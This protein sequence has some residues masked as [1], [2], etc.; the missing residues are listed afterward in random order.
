MSASVVKLHGMT[1]EHPGKA[2]LIVLDGFGIGKDSPFNAIRN[3]RR[4]FFNTLFS[5]Y[6]HSELFTHG[7]AVG[8]P[9]GVMGKDRKSTRLNSSHSTLSRMPSSA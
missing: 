8:L 7:N 3:A 2:L 1:V 5:R 4:P 6:P 9:N